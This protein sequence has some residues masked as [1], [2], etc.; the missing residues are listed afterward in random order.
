MYRLANFCNKRLI[1]AGANDLN[2]WRLTVTGV[3]CRWLT[4]GVSGISSHIMVDIACNRKS[5]SRVNWGRWEIGNRGNRHPIRTEGRVT[6]GSETTEWMEESRMNGVILYPDQT[7]L[8][9]KLSVTQHYIR[10]LKCSSVGRTTDFGSVGR[11]FEP[12][13]FNKDN[14]MG[15]NGRPRQQLKKSRVPD[16]N[17]AKVWTR[18]YLNSPINSCPTPPEKRL[19]LR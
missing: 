2:C 10:K 12:C 7:F 15:L 6:L 14:Q 19:G 17:H 11:R 4:L 16:K 1:Y 18:R 13:H 8:T 5:R 3:S 9:D